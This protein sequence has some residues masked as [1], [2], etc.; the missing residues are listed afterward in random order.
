MGLK[1]KSYID[2]KNNQVLS[3]VYNDI[4]V[5]CVFPN[6]TEKLFSMAY[7]ETIKEEENRSE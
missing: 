7:Y 6:D 4:P 1:L 2:K 5:K 3:V